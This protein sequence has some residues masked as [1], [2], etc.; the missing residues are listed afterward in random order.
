MTSSS[1][2]LAITFGKPVIAPRIASVRETIGAADGFTYDANDPNGLRDALRRC[3]VA[4]LTDERRHIERIRTALL[5]WDGV[6]QA[7]L[8]VYERVLRGRRRRS[9]R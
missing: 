1:L 5:D 8:A 4:D 6:A 9:P 7:T 3:A 2:H